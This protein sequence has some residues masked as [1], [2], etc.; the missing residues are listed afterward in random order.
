MQA[1]SIHCRPLTLQHDK[2]QDPLRTATTYFCA[3]IC[4][5][6]ACKHVN[7]N[8]ILKHRKKRILL[9]LTYTHNNDKNTAIPWLSNVLQLLSKFLLCYKGK[10]RNKLSWI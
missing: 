5:L 1:T 8:Y 6:A 7:V 3:T 2:H 4:P 10:L 9:D